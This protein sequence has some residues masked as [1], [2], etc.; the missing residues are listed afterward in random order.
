M[1]A[2]GKQMK[3]EDIKGLVAYIRSLAPP[4]K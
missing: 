2:Y 3:P 1:P 4:A